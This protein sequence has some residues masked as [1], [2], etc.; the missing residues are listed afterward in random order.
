MSVERRVNCAAAGIGFPGACFSLTGKPLLRFSDTFNKD[1]FT[2]GFCFMK[3][4][5][6]VLQL[7]LF[8]AVF[9]VGSIILPAFGLLPNKVVAIG[10]HLLFTYDGVVLMLLVY[11]LVLAIE[12]ARRRLRSGGL[13]TIAFVLAL[14]L[15]FAMKFG[16][17]TI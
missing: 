2:G 12:A 14:V 11:L 10:N 7:L 1:T 6:A 4:V 3:I 17:K 15:G 8:L 9:F 13:T 16:L 5:L